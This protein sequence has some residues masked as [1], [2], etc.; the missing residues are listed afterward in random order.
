VPD[1]GASIYAI[2]EIAGPLGSANVF[3]TAEFD[4][5]VTVWSVEAREPLATFDTVYELGGRRLAVLDGSP[6]IVV[7]GAW[8]RH[9]VCAYEATSGCLLWQRRDLGQ[10]QTLSPMPGGRLGVGFERRVFH[11]L[12]ASSGETVATIRG[13]YSLHAAENLPLMLVQGRS[14]TRWIGLYDLSGARVWRARISS[15]AI[16]DAALGPDAI[17]VAEV[18]SPLTCLDWSGADRWHWV[19]P[20]GGDVI[21]VAWND[22]AGAWA[23]LCRYLR[24]PQ[25]GMLLLE[26]ATDGEIRSS[27]KIGDVL[28]AEFLAGG[29]RLVV[30]RIEHDE[31][32]GGEVLRVPSGEQVW[33]FLAGG[34]R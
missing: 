30:S 9:G 31:L 18:G 5:R 20:D 25:R 2:R 12:L 14:G 24:E 19:S 32:I 16:Q 17:L 21:R 4:G 7:A 29:S 28:E 27:R 11:V 13:V 23:A 8:A 6:P 26:L 10:V 3:A 22:E 34:E 15:F 1:P 33:S